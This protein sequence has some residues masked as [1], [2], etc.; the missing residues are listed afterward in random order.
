MQNNVSPIIIFTYRRE[1]DKLLESLL[2][3]KLSKESQ[4]Y[5]FSDG[6]KNSTDKKD[7]LEVRESLKNIYGFKDIT[8]YESPQN[9]GL[10]TSVIDGVSKIITQHERV[11]VLEDDLIVANNFLEYMNG[12][13]DFY[14]IEKNIWSISGYTPKLECLENYEKNLFLSPRASSWG[15]ATWKDRW[16]KNDWSISDWE[17]FKEDKQAINYFNLA[18]NDMF[19]MLETQMLGKIDSWAIRW[20]YNQF[21]YN[22]FTVYPT[23]SKIINKGFDIKGTH[24]SHGFE[25]W[26]VEISNKVVIFESLVVNNKLIECFQKKYNLQLKTRIGYFLKQYGGYSFVKKIRKYIMR[27]VS[28]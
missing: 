7:V 17:E 2:K 9:K 10:A 6:Y 21:R 26:D 4:L 25:R 15:W 28:N 3:N 18:G 20:C 27:E 11:I 19:K 1:I 23:Q 16:L 22:S 13:L 5:I 24:N 8:I 12:A 14:K